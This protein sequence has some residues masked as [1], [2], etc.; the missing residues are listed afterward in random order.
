M[1]VF[2]ARA[3]GCGPLS[4]T[5]DYRRCTVAMC[6]PSWESHRSLNYADIV[7]CACIEYIK[8]L[9]KFLMAAPSDVSRVPGSVATLVATHDG[10]VKEAHGEWQAGSE[11]DVANMAVLLLQDVGGLLT[12]W[13]SA[14]PGGRATGLKRVS[15]TQPDGTTYIITLDKDYIYV[16]KSR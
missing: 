5:I 7:V 3:R 10:R 6:T 2:E 1:T 4:S 11:A 9:S 12:H 15:S 14:K 16:S 13:S 8:L